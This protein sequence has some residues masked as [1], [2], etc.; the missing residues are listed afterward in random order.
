MPCSY[1]FLLSFL[2]GAGYDPEAAAAAAAAGSF[3]ERAVRTAFVRKVFLLVAL[4]IAITTGV[5]C[6]FM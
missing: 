2:P 1:S 4:Q 3:A 6:V 5:A